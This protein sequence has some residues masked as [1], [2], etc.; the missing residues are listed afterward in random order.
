MTTIAT[1]EPIEQRAGL[2]WQWRRED[3]V[4][5]YPATLWTLT[6]WFKKIGA[7]GANFSIVASADGSQFAVTVSAATSG[8]Y[9]AGD[10]KWVAVVTY[11]SEAFE[12][13]RG[14]FTL[15]AKYNAAANLDDRSHARITL[16]A[17]EAV[18]EGRATVDQQEYTIGTRHLKR[19][20]LADLMKFRDYYRSQVIAED[21]KA[22]GHA[23]RLVARL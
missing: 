8:A 23:S 6:Y 12:V 15:L 13:D 20:P 2:T 21:N 18:I 17:I 1:N 16:D 10:Y 22:A 5:D 9:T 14:E 19:T 3:L 4:T 7:A 11:G